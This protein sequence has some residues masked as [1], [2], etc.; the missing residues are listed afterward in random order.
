MLT[1][2]WKENGKA[3][4]GLN[5]DIHYRIVAWCNKPYRKGELWV[6]IAAHSL[7]S[8][9]SHLNIRPCRASVDSL[10]NWL[11]YK[12]VTDSGRQTCSHL[13]SATAKNSDGFVQSTRTSA[14][15]SYLYPFSLCN[16]YTRATRVSDESY[17]KLLQ[18]IPIYLGNRM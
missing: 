3:V 17:M 8:I 12:T 7:N 1:Q 6:L 15:F 16:S 18:Y 10:E 14:I 5:P 11:K 9:D 13:G 4:K 2:N